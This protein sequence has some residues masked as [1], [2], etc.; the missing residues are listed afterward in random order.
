[1]TER[2][3][4]KWWTLFAM[5]FALFMIMLD[6]TIVNVALPTIQRELDASPANLEWIVNGYVVTFAAL[7]LLGGKLGDRF[8]RKR[9][10]IVGVALFTI[11]S[12]LCAVA[13]TDTQLIFARCLQGTGA[14]LM[15][16]LSL[17]ILVNAFP[18]DADPD[19]DRRLGRHLRPRHRDR[20]GRRRRAGRELRLG[21][22]VLG[23]RPDR[24]DRDRGLPVGGGGVARPSATKPR[25]R[26]HRAGDGQPAGAHVRPDQDQRALLDVGR[27]SSRC[28][29]APSC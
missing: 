3:N 6:N 5:C 16:P 23:Q 24:R 4:H 22:G 8:G 26:R 19:G 1:M 21:V 14:A 7:I 9:M 27:T 15:N 13:D 17:S 11:F 29:A 2:A 10:F 25:H 18:R 28:W 12:A 20:P